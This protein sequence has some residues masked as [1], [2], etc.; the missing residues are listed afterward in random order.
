[1]DR[2]L[3]AGLLGLLVVGC[4]QSRS[5]LPAKYGQ[6]GAV[7]AVDA[8]PPINVDINQRSATGDLA[9]RRASLLPGTYKTP[10]AGPAAP[11]G[12]GG[13][14]TSPPS[15]VTPAKVGEPPVPPGA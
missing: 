11:G 15:G 3:I 6:I 12:T 7:D 13:L 14:P 1:M 4:A 10:A 8:L 9:A 2:R 5:G